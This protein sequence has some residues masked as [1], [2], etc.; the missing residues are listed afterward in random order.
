MSDHSG[1]PR[2]ITSGAGT[3]VSRHDYLPFGEELSTV[4]MRTSGQGYGAADAARQKYAGME[5][6][7]GS[8]MATTLWRKYDSSSGRW[9]SPDPYGGSMTIASPQT[10]NRYS[11]VSNDPVN[12]R[13]PSGLMTMQAEGNPETGSKNDDDP[14]GD[15]FETGRS[16]TGATAA[17][18]ESAI[19]DRL[20]ELANASD[21][22]GKDGGTA[23]DDGKAGSPPGG[24][25]Q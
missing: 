13:D 6:D 2:V 15:P 8:G 25:P 23:G 12:M 22:G 3:V 11:Y 18:Q 5:S 17:R 7:D 9:T 19:R 16:I 21:S 20:S 14:P 4:G 24:E 1:S 10:F